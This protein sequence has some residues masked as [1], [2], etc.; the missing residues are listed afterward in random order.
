MCAARPSVPFNHVCRS[1]TCARSTALYGEEQFDGV[2]VLERSGGPFRAG[3][4]LAVE[5]DG[6]A[7]GG[8]GVAAPGEQVGEQRAVGQLFR[9][10]VE[11]QV[12]AGFL[13]SK[14]SGAKGASDAGGRP[15]TSNSAIRSPVSGA[16][17]TPLR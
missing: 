9:G 8:R 11:C 1:T 5:G 7:A 2:A 17:R 15:E 3:D 14:R 10:P 4:D 12:H 16:S 13:R 6:D